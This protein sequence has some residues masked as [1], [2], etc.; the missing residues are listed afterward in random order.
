MKRLLAWI[1]F[2]AGHYW[3]RVVVNHWPDR[4]E[5]SGARM[6]DVYTWLMQRS[7][8]FDVGG[9]VWVEEPSETVSDGDK[10]G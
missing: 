7:L 1:F 6:A 9:W 8:A 10:H 4:W 3:S 2:Y 5:D